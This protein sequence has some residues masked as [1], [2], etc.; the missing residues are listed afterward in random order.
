MLMLHK[1]ADKRP[2]VIELMALIKQLRP[3]VYDEG[4]RSVRIAGDSKYER[5]LA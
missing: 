1:D 2:E 4:K 3:E 5:L